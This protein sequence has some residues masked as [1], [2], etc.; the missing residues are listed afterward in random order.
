MR[1]VTG[2]VRQPSLRAS[3][4]RAALHSQNAISENARTRNRPK[5]PATLGSVFGEHTTR[6]R[7]C[8]RKTQSIHS[9]PVRSVNVPVFNSRAVSRKPC[10]ETESGETRHIRPRQQWVVEF[11]HFGCDRFS[12][13]G[14]GFQRR[15]LI[16]TNQVGVLAGIR[17]Q[18]EEFVPARV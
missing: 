14:L 11:P 16:G 2:E 7:E 6:V 12:Q 5:N 15:R 3:S 9:F 13:R 10:W 17:P 4:H 8:S 18:V 1:Q